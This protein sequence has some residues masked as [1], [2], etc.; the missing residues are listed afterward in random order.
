MLFDNRIGRA[1]YGCNDDTHAQVRRN[2][3]PY[4]LP[5]RAAGPGGPGW[6]G[7]LSCC[8]FVCPSRLACRFGRCVRLL[9]PSTRRRD[10]DRRGIG[11]VVRIAV[12]PDRRSTEHHRPR[13]GDWSRFLHPLELH[14]SGAATPLHWDHPKPPDSPQTRESLNPVHVPGTNALLSISPCALYADRLADRRS[15]S[16]ISP[17]RESCSRPVPRS[18]AALRA[19]P[20]SLFA[21]VCCSAW[22]LHALPSSCAPH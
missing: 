12:R 1:D 3:R 4:R 20:V 13:N 17:P 18:V 9:E 15:P 19:D 11:P 22:I 16:T 2:R 5:R 7:S 14:S 8:V 10:T 21:T 6:I